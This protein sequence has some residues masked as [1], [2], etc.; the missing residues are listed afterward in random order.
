MTLTKFSRRSRCHPRVESMEVRTLLNAGAL[1]TTYGGTGMVTTPIQLDSTSLAVAV[2]PDLK[3]VV[4]G[5]SDSGPTYLSHFTIARYNPNGTLDTSFGS[6]GVAVI[7]LSTVQG[8]E[9]FAVAIQPDGKIV[10]AGYSTVAG[11]K[12]ATYSDDWAIVRLNTNGTLDSTFGGGTGYVL[13]NFA[14]A[15]GNPSYDVASAIA[16]Q[17]NGQI[18]VAGQGTDGIAVVRYNANGTLDTTFGTS[19]VV[20]TGMTW[21][22]DDGQAGQIVAIDGSG[23]IDVAGTIMGT[24]DTWGIA[25][26]LANGSLDPTFGTEGFVNF[27]PPGSSAAVARSIALQSTGK[28][29][30]YGQANYAASHSLEPTLVR[31]NTDGS[32]DTTFGAGGVYMES[33]MFVAM[34]LVIQP[35]DEIL[36]DGNGAV[37]GMRDP[38]T[39]VTRVLANGSSYDPSFGTNGLTETNFNANGATPLAPFAVAL[40]PDG[41]IVLAGINDLVFSSARFLGGSMSPTTA[42]VAQGASATTI[43]PDPTLV[44]IVL[45]QSLFVDSLTST[46]HRRTN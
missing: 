16:L 41:N 38:Q 30:V 40:G 17:S 5:Y 10:A 32:L 24:T 22:T 29:V 14:A 31:L 23:R 15:S 9:A 21:I 37:N 18:V 4:A 19:G 35:D 12:K 46:K 39:W 3:V 7:P 25:R 11:K 20:N 27:L 26:L 13:T 33:R 8:D 28:I 2:Q 43:A 44:P 42:L 1:D 36:A 6:G 45:D 34:S